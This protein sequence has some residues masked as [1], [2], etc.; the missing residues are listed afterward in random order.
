MGSG[1]PAHLFHNPT[2]TGTGTGGSTQ[3]PV[4]TG[5]LEPGWAFEGY[6]I[7]ERKRKFE[8]LRPDKL[9]LGTRVTGVV[10]EI[11]IAARRNN[12]WGGPY[13]GIP[14]SDFYVRWHGLLKIDTAGTYEFRMGTDDG[15]LVW[16]DGALVTGYDGPRAY[17]TNTGDVVLSRGLHTIEMEFY[18][19]GG[20]AQATLEFHLKYVAG[21][22][23]APEGAP[24]TRRFVDQRYVFRT[25]E[26]RD[27]V[28][29]HAPGLGTRVQVDYNATEFPGLAYPTSDSTVSFFVRT[30]DDD[31]AGAALL[32]Y[33]GYGSGGA[34]ITGGSGGNE[35]VCLMDAAGKLQVLLFG[36]TLATGV[37]IRDGSWH[38]I[39][40]AWATS[41]SSRNLRVW[42]DGRDVYDGPGPALQGDPASA[43][44]DESA[45]AQLA[46]PSFSSQGCLMLGQIASSG[47]L[48]DGL[49]A[50]YE[51]GTGLLP[52]LSLEGY[53][54]GL[55]VWSEAKDGTGARALLFGSD[56]DTLTGGESG[57]VTGLV[58]GGITAADADLNLSPAVAAYLRGDT[59]DDVLIEGLEIFS[60]DVVGIEDIGPQGAHGAI[61]GAVRPVFIEA[62]ADF[63]RPAQPGTSAESSSSLPTLP[64]S[65]WLTFGTSQAVVTPVTPT[66]QEPNP[67]PVVT[68][69]DRSGAGNDATL[70][71]DGSSS[72][73][74][75]GN[76]AIGGAASA[77][78]RMAVMGACWDAHLE[79]PGLAGYAW[80]NP[81]G[82]ASG[83]ENDPRGF[84]AALFYRR[85]LASGSQY[86]FGNGPRTSASWE[87]R[88]PDNQD[89][90]SVAALLNLNGGASPQGFIANAPLGDWHTAVITYDG[91]RDVAT[92][93]VDGAEVSVSGPGALAALPKALLIGSSQTSSTGE[94]RDRF[95]GQLHDVRLY[96][97]P[98][99]RQEARLLWSEYNH[100]YWFGDGSVNDCV[101]SDWSDWTPCS[102][103]SG[104]SAASCGGAAQGTPQCG[105]S[106]VRSRSRTI[107]SGS[108]GCPPLLE[109]EECGPGLDISPSPVMVSADE[110]STF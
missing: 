81:T 107:L 82:Q 11:N 59:S 33:A 85:R 43:S 1:S 53:V 35:L 24:T 32:S 20:E 92:F 94:G 31:D 58:G 88:S 25:S 16:I 78:R 52:Q 6:E 12:V 47:A 73:F 34:S 101:V 17:R 97:R 21:G 105:L 23:Q 93:F 28:F 38:H 62:D 91:F 15:G 106:A 98:L 72:D 5:G 64:A 69:S 30:N 103:M 9:D 70:R 84:T 45:R 8:D 22:G 40:V 89:G 71:A 74:P 95:C 77:A 56:S 18:E 44:D 55:T 36:S 37:Q 104:G 54:G 100:R 63:Q 19:H 102:P 67:P 83:T 108:V 42:V 110:T 68:V 29:L 2:G 41:S 87:V 46:G 39:A 49:A 57:L 90:S 50:S 61:L 3:A 66:Q 79:V 13:Q 76:A 26:R 14:D 48:R 80:E 60:D 7:T 96:D 86:L 75:F 51:C 10:D 27:K 4:D 65:L 99:D 109:T